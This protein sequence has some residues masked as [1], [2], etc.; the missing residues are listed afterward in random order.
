VKVALDFANKFKVPMFVGEFS[1]TQPNIDEVY[2]KLTLP[3]SQQFPNQR[4]SEVQ[5]TVAWQYPLLC[6]LAAIRSQADFNALSASDQASAID[7]FNATQRRWITRP[8]VDSQG[9]MIATMGHVVNGDALGDG[10]RVA[11]SPTSRATLLSML[12][13]KL[14]TTVTL[15]LDTGQYWA[16]EGT[17][18][19]LNDQF[20]NQPLAR[21]V[22]KSGSLNM[23]ASSCDMSSGQQVTLVRH[24]ST[25]TFKAPAG[26]AAGTVFDGFTCTVPSKDANGNPIQ[27]QL[28]MPVALLMLQSPRS[29]AEIDQS[30]FD[31]ARDCL[32]VWRS[33]G[34]SWSWH[35]DDSNDAAAYLGWRPSAD[36]AEL[37]A[38]AAAGRM[39]VSRT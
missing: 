24:A 39:L 34:F 33:N 1:A 30:R 7:V 14:G 37:M 19:F 4:L 28:K 23:V 8:E 12:Q 2:P 6:K 18:D 35:A 10:F 5:N 20:Y 3:R 32:Q 36:I 38:S 15:P 16:A 27:V 26:V 29:T 25:I 13:Q 17:D 11:V 21:V 22:G 9:N 31:F